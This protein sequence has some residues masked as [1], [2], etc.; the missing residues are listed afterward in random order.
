[1]T[2]SDITN[3]LRLAGIR[4]RRESQRCLLPIYIPLVSALVN[5]WLAPLP[6][7]RSSRSSTSRWCARAVRGAATPLSVSVV[8]PA[9]NERG[10]IAAASSSACRAMGPADELIF[11]EGHSTDG[12]WDEIQRVAARYP[13]RRIRALQQPGK[14]Q[15]R[16]RAARFL[17]SRR[18][19]ADD[20]RRRPDGAARGR[21]PSSTSADRRRPGEFINGSRLVYPMETRGDAVRQHGRQQVLRAGLLVPARATAQ[22]HAVRHEGAHGART[23]K[24]IAREPRLL[25]RLRSVRR[26]RPALRRGH[27]RGCG[28]SNCRSAIA[29]AS[30]AT[31]NIQRW[32]HGWLLLRMTL[33]CGAPHEV[34][35][36]MPK[37][38]PDSS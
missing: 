23:T 1:M 13:H 30:T 8:V 25:R 26:L 17:R 15:R 22:G 27:A 19:R 3:L 38:F 36:T 6:V 20:P 33:V 18:R 35:L 2:P 7:L 10:N 4:A 9:R 21:C 24:R 37:P 12:T 11:V 34:H 5:R 31:T 14:G 16:R 32:V 29:S 28:S